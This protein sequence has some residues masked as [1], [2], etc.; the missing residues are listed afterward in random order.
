MNSVL[1]TEYTI[2]I[3]LY[4]LCVILLFYGGFWLAGID[5]PYLFK[6]LYDKR[7]R[8][9]RKAFIGIARCVLNEEFQKVC[10]FF[11]LNPNT[12]PKP[13]LIV[14]FRYEK[15]PGG[16]FLSPKY[17]FVQHTNNITRLHETLRH[18]VIHYI[19]Y[20]HLRDKIPWSMRE[21]FV[22]KVIKY[23]DR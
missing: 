17:I 19:H 18:E 3:I 21:I 6:Y 9:A 12:T 15:E 16:R 1:I 20:N 4:I 2:V 14:D 5:L 13:V 7:F 23:M 8:E 22:S 10:V 11:K